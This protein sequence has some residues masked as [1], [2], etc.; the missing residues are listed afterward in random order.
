[1]H[2]QRPDQVMPTGAGQRPR[3]LSVGFFGTSIMEHLEAFNAQMAN[4][5]ALPAV[6]SRVTVEGWRRRGW[7]HR[8]ALS[9]RAAWPH[10]GFDIRNHALGGATSRDIAGI[11]ERDL[12]TGADYDLVFL[13]CGINDV[14]RRFQNRLPEA[15]D[16]DE[17][18]QHLEA[19]LGGLGGSTRTTIVMSEAPFG[20]VESP[21]TVAA[22]NA[23]LARYNEAARAAA[24]TNGA[25]FLDVWAPFT[26]A[27]RHLTPADGDDP[28]GLWSDGVHLTELGDT[29]LLQQA[30]RLLA[31]HRIIDRLLISRPDRG[32]A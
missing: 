22:M 13:G 1:M 28:A 12:A 6:G 3:T 9:L 25:L 26:A 4:Q 15:V 18:A 29:L 27:A 21:G 2:E 32:T 23:E 30:E 20:P 19:M 14:W 17:Y 7:V 16:L 24:A 11:V 10:V 31:E 8:L 5:A